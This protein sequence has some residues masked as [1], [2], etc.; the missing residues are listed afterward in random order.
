MLIL[1][2]CLFMGLIVTG[3]VLYHNDSGDGG[4][5]CMSIG[6]FLSLIVAIV[7]IVGGVTI[8]ESKVKN[9]FI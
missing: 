3:I 2:L 5:A 1:M 6:S 9:K 8:S 4:I 7:L